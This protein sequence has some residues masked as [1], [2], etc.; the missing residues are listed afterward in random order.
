[1]ANSVVSHKRSATPAAVPTSLEFGELAINYADGKLFFKAANGSIYQIGGDGNY[2]GTVNANGSVLVADTIND[3]LTI[4]PGT[5]IFITGDVGTDTFTITANLAGPWNQANA[6][7]SI[8]RAGLIHANGAFS[9]S[10]TTYTY[11][12]NT[13]QLIANSAYNKANTG[14][15]I[16]QAAIN[17]AN[18]AYNTANAAYASVFL[19]M[20][21]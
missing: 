21:G 2:F 17:T 13:V 6:A 10:N 4:N 18:I 9:L 11:A 5:N 8:G 7:N 19:L 14:N 16:A 1:M 12:A 15:S 3:I 20:G